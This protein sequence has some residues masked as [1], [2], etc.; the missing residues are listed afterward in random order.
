MST[1]EKEV[2]TGGKHGLITR[3]GAN[4]TRTNYPR[5]NNT[6]VRHCHVTWSRDLASCGHIHQICVHLG[7]LVGGGGGGRRVWTVRSLC[8]LDSSK[9]QYVFWEHP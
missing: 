7:L 6:L 2:V 9:I 1:G 4:I 3:L 8:D 5:D